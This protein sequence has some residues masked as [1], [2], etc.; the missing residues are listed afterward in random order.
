MRGDWEEGELD[1]EKATRLQGQQHEKNS[2]SQQLD[3]GS[4]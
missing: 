1:E 4:Q 3:V 2:T